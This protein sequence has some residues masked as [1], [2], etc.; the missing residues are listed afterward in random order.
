[1]A[2]FTA[3]CPSFVFLLFCN[4]LMPAVAMA[5]P[6]RRL[7]IARSRRS[8]PVATAHS[9]SQ[10]DSQNRHSI[11]NHP[12]IHSLTAYGNRPAAGMSPA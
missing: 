5:V 6:A 9:G 3:A 1:M 7:V 12:L 10:D 11:R 4:G 8:D 2:G